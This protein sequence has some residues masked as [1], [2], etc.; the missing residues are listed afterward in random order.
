MACSLFLAGNITQDAAGNGAYA[1]GCYDVVTAIPVPATNNAKIFDMN[2][3]NRREVLR[4]LVQLTRKTVNT[5][6]GLRRHLLS[7]TLIMG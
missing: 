1:E 5:F 7:E 3:S 6:I 4:A 2:T